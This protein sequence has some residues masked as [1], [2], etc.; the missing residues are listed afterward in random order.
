VVGFARSLVDAVHVHGTD[1]VPLVDWEILRTA[2]H[3]A[4]AREDDAGVRVHA[5]AGLDQRELGRAVDLQILERRLHRVLVARLA[6]EVEDEAAILHQH[7]QPVPVA[8]V[9]DVEPD[10]VAEIR[11]VVEIAPEVVAEAVD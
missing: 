7:A 5:S 2:V 11:D 4:R 1:R 6:R 3:L 8:D 9:R 10:L